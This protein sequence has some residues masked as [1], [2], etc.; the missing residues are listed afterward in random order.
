MDV[1]I[2]EQGVSSAAPAPAPASAAV[3]AHPI[4]SRIDIDGETY[5]ICRAALHDVP[6]LLHLMS[7]APAAE[8][9]RP[10]AGADYAAAFE[11]IDADP[12]QLLAA[13]HDRAGTVVGM[14]QL[15]LLPRLDPAASMRLQIEAMRVASTARGHGLG[16]AM[17]DWAHAWGRSHGATMSQLAVGAGRDGASGYFREH[18]YEPSHIGM[19][20][21]LT[22]RG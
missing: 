6:A 5:T 19:K 12:S 2:A 17:L 4:S 11:R 8:R 20:R 7:D 1:D 10:A 16:S 13:V 3:S 9:G 15:T 21:D 18:G 22:R 14:M